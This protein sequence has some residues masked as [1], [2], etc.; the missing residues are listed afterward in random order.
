MYCKAYNKG[1]FVYTTMTR[2][3]IDV[4]SSALSLLACIQP[5]GLMTKECTS[6]YVVSVKV[7]SR[8][9]RLVQKVVD[10]ES[11]EQR[12][13]ILK[14]LIKKLPQLKSVEL[15]DHLGIY[16]LFLRKNCEVCG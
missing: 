13:L 7:N 12:I 4:Q 15:K 10:Q 3:T 1:K 14:D 6:E 8:F 16:I 11:E 5:E 2:G 9:E